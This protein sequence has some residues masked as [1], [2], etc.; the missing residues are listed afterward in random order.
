MVRIGLGLLVSSILVSCATTVQLTPMEI[1]AL[2]TRDFEAGK[3]TVF[4]SVVSVFQDLGYTI[5]QADLDSGIVTAEGAAKTQGAW[6]LLG[7]SQ[8]KQSVATSFIEE[9]GDVTQV[10]LSFVIRTQAS[11]IYG[12]TSRQDEPVVEAEVYQNAFE[13][14][15]QAIFVRS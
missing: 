12:Q 8:N 10:R 9:I 5:T 14:I 6:A 1:Q 2:Q 13:Q 15:E 3:Q 11:G 4:N 7:V